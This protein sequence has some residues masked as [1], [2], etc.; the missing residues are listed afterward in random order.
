[1]NVGDRVIDSGVLKVMPGM[2]VQVISEQQA[3][4]NKAHKQNI[5][6]KVLKKIKHLVFR[7]RN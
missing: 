5:F 7:G 2:K 4:S 3:E 6:I 1:M